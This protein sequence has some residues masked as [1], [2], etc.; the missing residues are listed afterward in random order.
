LNTFLDSYCTN[1]W[2]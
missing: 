1:R 2:F